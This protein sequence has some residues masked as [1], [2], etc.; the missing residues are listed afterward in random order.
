MTG[1]M[2][3]WKRPLLRRD[4]SKAKYGWGLSIQDHCGEL[5]EVWESGAPTGDGGEGMN[6]STK[7]L[8]LEWRISEVPESHGHI[9]R[10]GKPYKR[11]GTSYV[12]LECECGNEYRMTTRS[13]MKMRYT[14]C[15]KCRG[16]WGVDFRGD[17]HDPPPTT[18]GW[19]TLTGEAY[20][21]D[22]GVW[23]VR[24]TCRCGTVTR[25]DLSKWR[26]TDRPK[27]CRKCVHAYRNARSSAAA[28][29]AGLKHA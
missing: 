10:V 2:T 24:T 20:R 27:S 4:Y 8:A 15:V 28:D 17:P 23:L 21:N 29:V 16:K 25:Q 1:R 6:F 11:K 7:P 9:K 3:A 12:Q 22:R 5:E 14:R 19:L 13:W 26:G 18:S